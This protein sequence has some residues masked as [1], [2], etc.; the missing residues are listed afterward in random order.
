MEDFRNRIYNFMSG[1]YGFDQFGRFLFL[2]GLVTGFAGMFLFFI[3]FRLGVWIRS[4]FYVINHLC[5]IYAVFRIFSR[6]IQKRTIENERYIRVRN[7]VLPFIEKKTDR[8]YVY[9]KCPKCGAMLRL[10]RIKGKHITQCPK[11]GIKFNVRIFIQ[12]KG[13]EYKDAYQHP[14]DTH[15]Y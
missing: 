15:N 4:I 14:Y 10:K 1:R 5:Y 13:R 11:C 9:K 8:N 7:K 6:N 3:P 2:L 12:Y